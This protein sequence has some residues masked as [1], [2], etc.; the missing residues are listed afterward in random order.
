LWDFSKTFLFSFSFF[1]KIKF[2]LN[3]AQFAWTLLLRIYFSIRLRN[4]RWNCEFFYI[5]S[6]NLIYRERTKENSSKRK[7]LELKIFFSQS[8]AAAAIV[9]FRRGFSLFRYYLNIT[10]RNKLNHNVSCLNCVKRHG[11]HGGFIR[12]TVGKSTLSLIRKSFLSLNKFYATEKIFHEKNE[13]IN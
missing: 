9:F 8:F 7:K 5:I 12:Y 6:F 4:M 2:P 11:G 10:K 3:A 13:A 1:A